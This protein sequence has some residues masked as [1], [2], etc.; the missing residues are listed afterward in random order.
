MFDRVGG[1]AEKL[2]TNVSRRAFL[3]RLGQGALVTVGALA[4]LLA[5]AGTAHAMSCPPGYGQ[6]GTTPTGR[7]GIPR[8]RCCPKGQWCCT[9]NGGQT[10][11]TAK[12][13]G[14]KCFKL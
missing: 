11:S 12:L 7:G 6:C 4:G 13:P 1:L 2:V 9:C 8:P 10:C 5:S 3:G 14:C